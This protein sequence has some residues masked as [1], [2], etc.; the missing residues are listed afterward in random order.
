MYLVYVKE[1]TNSMTSAVQVIQSHLCQEIKFLG[2]MITKFTCHRC[3]RA[4]LSTQCPLVL[5]GNT[6]EARAMCPFSTRVKH[7]F[8]CWLGAP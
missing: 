5:L 2:K 1:G 3:W 4:K 6:A 7:S 8:S